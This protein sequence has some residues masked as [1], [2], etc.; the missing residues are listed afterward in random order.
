MFSG[1]CSNLAV[2]FKV[3]RHPAGGKR[4]SSTESVMAICRLTMSFMIAVALLIAP[5]M[6]DPTQRIPKIGVLLHS[7]SNT[8]LQEWLKPFKQRLQEHGGWRERI[9]SSNIALQEANPSDSKSRLPNLSSL[10]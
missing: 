8:E 5:A 6:A 1:I 9:S 7:I 10:G 2:H 4:S 3:G